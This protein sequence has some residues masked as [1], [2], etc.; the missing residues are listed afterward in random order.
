MEGFNAF[1]KIG[2]IF[3]NNMIVTEKLD[4]TN[5]QVYI[6]PCDSDQYSYGFD[7]E[8]QYCLG[9]KDGFGIAAGS[10]NRY[11]TPEA[12]NYGFAKWVKEN[13]DELFKLGEGRHYGE[14]WGKGIQRGYG[15]VK[16]IFSLFNTSRWSGNNTEL[17]PSCCEVVPVLGCWTMDTN[18]IKEI[19]EELKTTGSRAAP[20]F[21]DVEGIVVYHPASNGLFKYTVDDNHKDVKSE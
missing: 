17:R 21:M 5:A 1:P 13:Q 9:T 7:Q 4:G 14:W 15:Q 10:R 3:K 12:D 6:F 20:G 16:K 19:L 2:R 11:I 8:R 18:K